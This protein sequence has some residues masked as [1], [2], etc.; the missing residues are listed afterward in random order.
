MKQKLSDKIE[1]YRLEIKNLEKELNRLDSH[2]IKVEKA[3]QSIRRLLDFNCNGIN[4]ILMDEVVE[5]IIVHKEWFE[6]KLVFLN[7]PINLEVKN[8]ILSLQNIKN[9]V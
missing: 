1:L 2:E 9:K 8:K 4:D 3:K 5:K 7:E 6:C